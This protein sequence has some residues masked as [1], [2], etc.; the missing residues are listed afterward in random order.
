LIESLKKEGIKQ[1]IKK[2][3]KNNSES[4]IEYKVLPIDDIY[5]YSNINLK[6]PE[7]KP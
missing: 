1:I 2:V 5:D 6:L 4:N 3:N 7:I